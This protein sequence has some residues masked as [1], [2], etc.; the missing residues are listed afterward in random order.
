MDL[1]L[2]LQMDSARTLSGGDGIW[3]YPARLGA[4]PG[5]R[6][7][8]GTWQAYSGAR[9]GGRRLQAVPHPVRPASPIR[10]LHGLPQRYRG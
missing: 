7:S 4:R 1:P 2:L 10:A 6:I 8:H 9:Q 5:H 3:H